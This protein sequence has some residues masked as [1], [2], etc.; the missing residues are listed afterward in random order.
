MPPRDTTTA[1]KAIRQ[2]HAAPKPGDP[3]RVPAVADM[4]DETFIKHMEFRHPTWLEVKFTGR[5]PRTMGPNR[6]AFEALHDV[7]HRMAADEGHTFDH[8]HKEPETHAKPQNY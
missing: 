4:D 1:S 6:L 7:K 3:I 8:V 2:I 5:A